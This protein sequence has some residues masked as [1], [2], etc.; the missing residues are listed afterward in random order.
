M[1]FLTNRMELKDIQHLANLARIEVSQ[2]EQEALLKDLT[3]TLAYVDQVKRAQVTSSE[4]DVPDHR[5]IF[6]D[7]VVTTSRG[8]H[9]DVL[10]NEVPATQDGYVKVKKIL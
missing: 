6:R 5:N 4:T 7:D 3:S 9:T 10:L 2:E 8:Q 1:P